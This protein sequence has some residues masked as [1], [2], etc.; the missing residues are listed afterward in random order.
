MFGPR[1]SFSLGKMIGGLSKTLGVINEV[2]PLYKEAKPLMNN[3]RNA[4]NIIKDLSNNTTKR[5]I[6]NKEKNLKPLKEKI[7][8]INTKGPTFFQ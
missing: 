8:N 1:P 2:I 4:I 7:N 3:A 5:I 6:T